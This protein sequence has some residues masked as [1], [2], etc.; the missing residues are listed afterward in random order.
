MTLA[1]KAIRVE[2]NYAK[3]QSVLRLIAVRLQTFAGWLHS[4]ILK[5]LLI[6]TEIISFICFFLY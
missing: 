6:D 4:I 3:G 1:E 2:I 5:A